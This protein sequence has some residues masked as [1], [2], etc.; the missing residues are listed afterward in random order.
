MLNLRYHNLIYPS[1]SKNGEQGFINELYLWERLDLGME[2]NL[3]VAKV[4][5]VLL[6]DPLFLVLQLLES[7]I[8]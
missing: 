5:L 2:H 8:S 6:G 3:I 4:I 1:A 7:D